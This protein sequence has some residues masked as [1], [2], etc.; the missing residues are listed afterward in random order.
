ML[1]GI[2]VSS[3]QGNID[4]PAVRSAGIAFAYLKA[5]EGLE[6]DSNHEKRLAYFQSNW[7]QI[8]SAG[9]YRGAY[10]FF[11]ANLDSE[12][13]AEVFLQTIGS[14]ADADLPPMLDVETADGADPAMIALRVGRFLAKVEQE[15]GVTP[16]LYTYAGFWNARVSADLSAYPLWIASYGSNAATGPT[17]PTWTPTLPPAWDTWT[18]WQYT[19]RGQVA[20]IQTNVDLDLFDGTEQDLLNLASA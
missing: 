7:P 13:Q 14:L 11:R 2:D 6:L 10:H 20:G 3:S 5:T 12:R 18:L 9:L 19:S 15:T 4:W 17:V 8:A 16:I 1:Q